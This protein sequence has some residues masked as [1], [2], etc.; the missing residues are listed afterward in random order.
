MRTTADYD[1]RRWKFIYLMKFDE[2]STF[3]RLAKLKA[4]IVDK[5]VWS[6]RYKKGDRWYYGWIILDRPLELF[7]A[8]EVGL[9]PI[10]RERGKA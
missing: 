3:Q 1:V 4:R 2:T 8:M 10:F 9:I 5:N 7:D 6:Q